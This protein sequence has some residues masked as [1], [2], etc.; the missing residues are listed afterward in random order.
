M[1]V[2]YARSLIYTKKVMCFS[3]AILMLHQIICLFLF[4]NDIISKV[5]Y[6]CWLMA[7]H[8]V[9][10]WCAA[11]YKLLYVLVSCIFLFSFVEKCMGYL[12]L[13]VVC[14]DL[15]GFDVVL[16]SFPLTTPVLF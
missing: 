4:Y 16:D 12:L 15:G 2:E 7:V 14:V 10:C 5:A 3:L 9:S 1:M 6:L 13:W 11:I 8:G